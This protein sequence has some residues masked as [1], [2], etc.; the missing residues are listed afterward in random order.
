MANLRDIRDRIASVKNTQQITKAMKMVAAAKLRKAQ[1]RMLQT[2]PYA[3]KLSE[4]IG[5]LADGSE[6]TSIFLKEKSNPSTALL[7]VVGSDR[8]L[9]GGFN[10]NLFKATEIYIQSEL[11]SFQDSN[12]LSLITIGK[13]ATEYFKKRDYKVAQAYPGFFDKLQYEKSA[14]IMRFVMESFQKGTFESVYLSYNEF[15]TVISQERKIAQILPVPPI[16]GEGSSSDYIFEPSSE[17]I[18]DSLIPL[19]LNTQLWKALLESN[20]SEQG[21]R[22]AAM[23]NA[24]ENASEIIRQLKLKYNQARQAAITT[25][26]SEIVSG[27]EALSE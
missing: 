16:E 3:A 25:E 9:C 20:A 22:M 5:K 19:H 24:T 18:L 21:A 26:I 17:E 4:V 27:A 10:N 14:A 11:K 13:K 1:Q 15:K 8:G 6:T 2:R 12:S 7:V 23:D